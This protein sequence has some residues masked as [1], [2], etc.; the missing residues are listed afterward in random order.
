MKLQKMKKYSFLLVFFIGIT[1]FGQ[2][3]KGVLELI[4]KDGF[5][6][7]MLTSDIRAASK[8]NFGFIRIK[9]SSNQEVPYVLKYQ[10]DRLFATFLPIPIVSTTRIKDSVTA[11][12]IENK[13]IKKRTNLILQ[14][15]NTAISK[16]YNLLGSNDAVFWFGITSNKILNL[17]NSTN[18]SSTETSIN[19][20][21]NAYKFLKIEISDKNS[22][23]INVLGVGVY[24]NNFFSEES[25]L[26]SNFNQEIS[27]IKERKVTQI[28]FTATNYHEIN[29]ISFDVK[30]AFFM[31]N[32][33]IIAKRTHKIK[34]RAEVYDEVISSFELSSKN[35]N[36]FTLNNFYEKEFI[37][38]IDNQDN[39]P[40][41]ITAIKLLQ[42]PIY[43]ISNL[44]K[45]QKYELQI[46][47]S[48]LKPSY[49][50]GNFVSDTILNIEEVSVINFLKEKNKD[51][52]IIEKAFWQTPI[53][54]WICIIFVGLLIVYFAL[55]L[56]KDI[57]HQEK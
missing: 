13:T 36:T 55:D 31:R 3:Y 32:V 34:K 50:L 49:D 24:E 51:S 29:S 27:Q 21:I 47:T 45:N 17:K 2:N 19:F 52:K 40:L 53:F 9:D 42:K 57:K 56:L 18:T 39:P 10:S 6:K 7:I 48:F 28:K 54:M 46:D 1:C 15:A 37:V 44:K 41:E 11:I 20:P 5:H 4:K 30:S 43:I 16:R 14:I 8:N 22:L 25:I 33:K 38:E 12:L 23:P 35:E 26:I